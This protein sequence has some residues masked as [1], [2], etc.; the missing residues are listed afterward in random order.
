MRGNESANRYRIFFEGI[1]NVLHIIEVMAVQL[2][3]YTKTQGFSGGSGGRESASNAEELGLMRGSG[4][5]LGKGNDH[6]LQVSCLENSMGWG[7]GGYSQHGSKE[8]DT[9]E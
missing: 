1:E 7:P 8:S 3:D 4:R 6:T 9:T 5:C 2:C